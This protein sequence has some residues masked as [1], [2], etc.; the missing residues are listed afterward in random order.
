MN[1][2]M[3][4]IYNSNQ[5]NSK[6]QKD[7]TQNLFLILN[8]QERH[9]LKKLHIKLLK[10]LLADTPINFN[11]YD[12][13]MVLFIPKMFHY[14]PNRDEC[15]M[16]DPTL[17][18]LTKL[19]KMLKKVPNIPDSFI[20]WMDAIFEESELNKHQL[21]KIMGRKRAMKAEFLKKQEFSNE[22]NTFQDCLT[23]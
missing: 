8:D 12:M 19:D 4:Q 10:T 2:A 21:K 15:M 1:G 22:L 14:H 9:Y 7:S 17:T 20:D 13:E 3:M 5:Y 23:Y 11:H 6:I 16:L 18:Q